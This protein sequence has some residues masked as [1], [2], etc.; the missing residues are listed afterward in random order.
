MSPLLFRISLYTLCSM[1][2]C[3]EVHQETVV[4]T[5][6]TVIIEPM[7][8]TPYDQYRTNSFYPDQMVTDAYPEGDG[9]NLLQEEDML[10]DDPCA[11]VSCQWITSSWSACPVTCGQATLSRTVSCQSVQGEMVDPSYC[12]EPRPTDTT[13]TDCTI[14]DASRECIDGSVWIINSCGETVRERINCTHQGGCSNG[15]CQCDQSRGDHVCCYSEAEYNR[16]SG[17]MSA[18][19]Q[20]VRDTLCPSGSTNSDYREEVG[21]ND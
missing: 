3:V 13:T 7:R 15:T 11:H 10:M 16:F 8:A 5:S 2:A 20:I 12:H 6:E 1:I 17:C 21:C 9:L 19:A 14:E 4:N 18:H